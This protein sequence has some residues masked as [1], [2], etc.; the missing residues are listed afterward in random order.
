MLANDQ[1]TGNKS[2][3]MFSALAYWLRTPSTGDW[4]FQPKP[5]SNHFLKSTICHG[6]YANYKH[7]TLTLFSYSFVLYLYNLVF[8]A[9]IRFNTF[10]PGWFP[11]GNIHSS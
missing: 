9:A 7:P 1:G 4:N 3:S 6:F 11:C 10:D 8:L 2:C 5:P